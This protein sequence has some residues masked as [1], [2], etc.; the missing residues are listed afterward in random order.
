[1]FQL[2]RSARGSHR[3]LDGRLQ[4]EATAMAAGSPPVDKS[5]VAADPYPRGKTKAERAAAAAAEEKFLEK[6]ATR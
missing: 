2:Q 3:A 4:K 1:V 6:N 5:A